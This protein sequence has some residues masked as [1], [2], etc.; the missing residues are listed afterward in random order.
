MCINT[1]NLMS[2]V[3]LDCS[4][5]ALYHS[6]YQVPEK[7]QDFI[8]IHNYKKISIIIFKIITKQLILKDI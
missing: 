5:C 7:E 1:T 4:T 8:V 6:I 2:Q 3:M